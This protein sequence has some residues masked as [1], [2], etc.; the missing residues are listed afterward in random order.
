[1]GGGLYPEVGFGSYGN[2]VF[3]FLRNYH[4]IEPSPLYIPTNS[5]QGSRFYIFLS[6]LVIF[7]FFFNIV[8]ILM[9]MR[10]YLVV[11]I[12]IFLMINDVEH[13]SYAG[14]HLYLL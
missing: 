1:M 7:F 4:I 3:S 12:G 6:I 8:V 13:L 5:T 14:C 9:V 11:L 10:Q 2:T